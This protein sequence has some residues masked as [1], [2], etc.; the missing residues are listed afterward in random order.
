LL[1]RIDSLAVAARVLVRLRRFF[2]SKVTGD[3]LVTF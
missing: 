1:D 3:A 2:Y